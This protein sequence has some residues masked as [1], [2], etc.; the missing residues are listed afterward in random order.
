MRLTDS[1]ALA[2]RNTQARI[3]TVSVRDRFTAYGLVGE[4]IVQ[5]YALDT[6]PRGESSEGKVWEHLGGWTYFD[7]VSYDLR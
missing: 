4:A 1:R 7:G 3:Y 5:R 2:H 6:F